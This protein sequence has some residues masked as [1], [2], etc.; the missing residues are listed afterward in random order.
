MAIA[1][2]FLRQQRYRSLAEGEEVC[3]DLAKGREGRLEAANVTGPDGKNVIGTSI[4]IR[5]GGRNGPRVVGIEEDYRRVGRF[6]RDRR[7][8]EHSR[9]HETQSSTAPDTQTSKQSNETTTE[10]SAQNRSNSTNGAPSGDAGKT[11]GRGNNDE[12]VVEIGDRSGGGYRQR[13]GR[14]RRGRRRYRS[15]I[16][17]RRNS[18]KSATQ[19]PSKQQPQQDEK[20]PEISAQ[21]Q[22]ISS[23]S[24]TNG[25]TVQMR[26]AKWNKN[27]GQEQ[28]TEAQKA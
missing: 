11:N 17:S 9:D 12:H 2:S 10:N 1:K 21:K 28:T 24:P 15:P 23:S 20:A 19:Q 26:I 5:S 18:E 7:R 16:Q 4:V 22:E 3:F 14:F 13:N 8:R 25:G 27:N 6:R